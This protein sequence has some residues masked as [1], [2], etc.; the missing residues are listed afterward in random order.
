MSTLLG[1]ANSCFIFPNKVHFLMTFSLQGDGVGKMRV[2]VQITG[3]PYPCTYPCIF[4][5]HLGRG[6][7]RD[8]ASSRRF[9][10]VFT[11][12]VREG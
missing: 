5:T 2:W 11:P 8:S 9:P 7:D 10:Q 1:R 6:K 3:D 4:I 12:A